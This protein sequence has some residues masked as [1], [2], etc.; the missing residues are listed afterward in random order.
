MLNRNAEVF[1]KHKVDIGC[2]N[3]VEHE[4]EVELSTSQGRGEESD[5]TQSRSLQERNQDVNEVRHDRGVEVPVV[6]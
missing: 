1:S 3:F 2:C 6:L 4:I 5:P